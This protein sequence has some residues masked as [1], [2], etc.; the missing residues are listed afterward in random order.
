MG[1]DNFARRCVLLAYC[2]LNEWSN[3]IYFLQGWATLNSTTFET[4]KYTYYTTKNEGLDCTENYYN[5]TIISILFF[6]IDFLVQAFLNCFRRCFFRENVTW[7]S[8]LLGWKY[9]GHKQLSWKRCHWLIKRWKIA[10]S[11]KNMFIIIS[12]YPRYTL[13]QGWQQFWLAGHILNN[14]GPVHEKLKD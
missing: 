13:E 5:Y 10:N 4:N 14:D 7:T 8:F 9:S 3:S 2:W 6:E 1:I 12:E 11:S